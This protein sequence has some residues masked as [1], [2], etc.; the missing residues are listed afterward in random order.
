MQDLCIIIPTINRK[1]LLMKALENYTE[2]MPEV[3]KLILDNGN[4]D[5]PCNDDNTWIWQ[6]TQNLGVAASWNYL[7]GKAIVNDFKYFLILNDD[8]ILQ[9]DESQIKQILSKGTNAPQISLPLTDGALHFIEMSEPP[10]F[11]DVSI[12][13][14]AGFD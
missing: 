9:K 6:S 3:T 12:A 5:I 13:G 14:L 11:A 10:A 7:I 2:L 1:D 8:V 4:Q